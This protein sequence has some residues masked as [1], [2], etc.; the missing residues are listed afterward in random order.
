MSKERS[1]V[2]KS[3]IK[4]YEH[5]IE[6]LARKVVLKID[7]HR[8]WDTMGG[9]SCWNHFI[10]KTAGKVTRWHIL[11]IFCGSRDGNNYHE[12]H[13]EIMTAW[14]IK[15]YGVDIFDLLVA[16]SHSG[17]KPTITD[18]EK[19]EKYWVDAMGFQDRRQ[20]EEEWFRRGI[21]G[22]VEDELK[23][24]YLNWSDKCKNY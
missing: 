14:F 22:Q 10:S 21:F 17:Y 20:A 12:H 15:K 9:P 13:P 3:V 23:A 16:L 24:K 2:K 4:C 1:K 11:N 6:E 7:G 5:R 18:Y 8:N 19:L